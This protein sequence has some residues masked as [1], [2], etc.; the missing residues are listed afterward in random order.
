MGILRLLFA[1][2]VVVYHAREPHG[3]FLFNQTAAILS[4]FIISGFY[5]ALILDGKYRSKISFYASRALRIFPLYWIALSLTIILGFVKLLLHLGSSET[6]IS[7]YFQYSTYLT[8]I[9]AIIEFINFVLR[10]LTLLITKDFFQIQDNLAPGYLIVNPAWTLQIELLFYLLVPFLLLIKKN[11]LLFVV[12]YVTLFYGIIE[13]FSL[14]PEN[15]LIF[16]FLKYFLFFLLGVCSYRY[17]Y[18]HL[19]KPKIKR[20][21]VIVFAFFLLFIIGYQFLPG[22]ILDRSF[23]MGLTYYITF[24]LS[25]PYFFMLTKKNKLDR[26][27]GE[28]S[29]PVYITHMIF[30]KI[31]FSLHVQTYPFLNSI[32]I[33]SSTIIFSIILVVFIQ[34]P[35]DRLR[36][37]RL[38][39]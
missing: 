23:L 37:S 33:G 29:Y 26:F 25:I 18:K 16:S 7:H 2:S 15:N 32:L 8:G 11:F 21:P 39:N 35:I 31:L 10:N 20:L 5:M 22:R 12:F 34:N 4:F 13:P 3:L 9:P 38:R 1:L 36:H 6:S 30:A 14:I 19:K 17:V 28:L 27:L 24:A